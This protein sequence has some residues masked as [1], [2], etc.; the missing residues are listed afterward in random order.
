MLLGRP[1]HVDD[2]VVPDL[3]Y[4]AHIRHQIVVDQHRHHQAHMRKLRWFSP[5]PRA[6]VTDPGRPR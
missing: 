1:I 5:L 2:R 4:L 6:A 3:D